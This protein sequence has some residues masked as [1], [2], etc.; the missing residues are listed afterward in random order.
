MENLEKMITN[1]QFAFECSNEE[2]EFKEAIGLAANF[3]GMKVDDPTYTLAAVMYLYG[4]SVGIRQ[5]RFL[6]K[7]KK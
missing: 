3:M 1:I 7:K 4:K 6:R 2:K 5:T